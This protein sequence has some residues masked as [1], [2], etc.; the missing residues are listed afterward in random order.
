[1]LFR[2]M[3]KMV[4]GE[5]GEARA[6]YELIKHGYRVSIPSHVQIPYDLIAEKD[7]RFYRVQVKTTHSIARSTT[8]T[9]A[10]SLVTTNANTGSRKKLSKLE[11]DL[12]FVLTDDDRCWLIPSE[13][14]DDQGSITVGS[15]KFSTYQ[16]SGWRR[17]NEISEDQTTET[18][19]IPQKRVIVNNPPLSRDQMS[20][21][22]RTE[23][24]PN[25]AKMFN[26]SYGT[27]RRLAKKW[28][29]L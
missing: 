24:L 21:L 18:V 26:M 11:V 15:E 19:V 2:G 7:G 5:L 27:A 12:L 4:Q 3:S 13:V 10:V 20:E 6:V 17:V 9:Y 8:R 22:M 1:M 29:L 14:L 25:I 23:S 28:E 16:I